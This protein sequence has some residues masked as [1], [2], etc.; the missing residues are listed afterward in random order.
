MVLI[1]FK[2]TPEKSLAH[3]FWKGLGAPFMVFGSFATTIHIPK[4]EPVELPARMTKANSDLLG[5]AEDWN[6]AVSK[7]GKQEA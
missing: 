5:I 3:G 6:Q 7:Y 2:A 1:N 4:V